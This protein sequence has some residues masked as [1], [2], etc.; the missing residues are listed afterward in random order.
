M[1]FFFFI[2]H[3]VKINLMHLQV[4]LEVLLAQ[5]NAQDNPC[6]RKPVNHFVLHSSPWYLK[7]SFYTPTVDIT[8]VPRDKEV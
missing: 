5:N 2:R 7:A 6:F 3:S 8:N 4:F 1:Q